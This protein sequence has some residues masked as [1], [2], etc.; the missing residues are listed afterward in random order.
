V[1]SRAE[2][3]LADIEDQ[4][5]TTKERIDEL[6]AQISEKQAEIEG[7]EAD[8]EA[9]EADDHEEAL[10]LHREINRVELRTERLEDDLV[11][12]DE[13]SPIARQP[14]LSGKNY[15]RSAM[16]CPNGSPTCGRVSTGSRK[17]ASRRSRT[18][19]RQSSTFSNTR[20]S[21]ESGSSGA[22]RRSREGRRKVTTTRFDL[23]VVR[24]GTDGAA[25]E[26]TLN[27]L[28]ESEREVTRLVFA[29]AVY[30]VH[31][32]HEDVPFIVLDP[33]E[34]IDAG[35]IARVIE[36]FGDHAD[37]LVAALLPEDAAALPETYTYVEQ[38]D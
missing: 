30:L 24:S 38:I 9:I 33:L 23:H 28:S 27:H 4:I 37:Y 8:A 31:D 11:D 29:L 18:T 10:E 32:M 2:D 16:S 26:D 34:T 36:Y 25:Y 22:G 1:S 7:L 21:I 14:S 13:G 15:K 5:H 3:R 20:T 12:I 17:R 35:R 19:W 6:K